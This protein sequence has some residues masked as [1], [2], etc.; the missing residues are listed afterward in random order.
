MNLKQQDKSS[1][2]SPSQW[3][4]ITL[5]NFLYLCIAVIIVFACTD[6]KNEQTKK[7][8]IVNIGQWSL[9]LGKTGYDDIKLVYDTLQKKFFVI[10]EMLRYRDTSEVVIQKTSDLYKID[11]VKDWDDRYEVLE[12][13]EITMISK[14]HSN[15]SSDP[16]LFEKEKLDVFIST[17]NQAESNSIEWKVITNEISND[18]R[19]K[20]FRWSK[21]YV[22]KSIV[23]PKSIIYPNGKLIIFYCK[24]DKYK[25]EYSIKAKDLYNKY[26]DYSLTLKYK[27]DD[28]GDMVYLNLD[29]AK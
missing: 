22:E 1:S 23:N 11:Y 24:G 6:S 19:N 12:N 8:R 20:V 27:Y 14:G 28:K 21:D 4:L 10:D 16:I 9:F 3:N 25:M 26:I 13:G 18:E 7:E 5:K 17:A 29:I 2:F 15:V